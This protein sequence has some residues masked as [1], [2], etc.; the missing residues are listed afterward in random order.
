[1]IKHWAKVVFF[2]LVLLWVSA[3]L[4]YVKKLGELRTLSLETRD[5]MD[6]LKNFLESEQPADIGKEFK[7]GAIV[8]PAADAWRSAIKAEPYPAKIL[9][10]PVKPRKPD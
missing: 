10:T 9:G 1:M 3:T 5:T 2:L 7:A 6:E 8:S 4:V